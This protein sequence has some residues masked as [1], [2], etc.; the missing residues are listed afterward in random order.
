MPVGEKIKI[1]KK[2]K[3]RERE[4]EDWS[5]DSLLTDQNTILSEHQFNSTVRMHLTE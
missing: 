5:Q 3:E 2:K 4:R 1:K